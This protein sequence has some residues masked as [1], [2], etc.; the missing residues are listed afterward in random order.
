MDFLY[1]NSVFADFSRNVSTANHEGRLY[2]NGNL[3][4]Y[5]FE[6]IF[7]GKT[8]TSNMGTSRMG[9]S[10]NE[11]MG[12]SKMGTLKI[13]PQFLSCCWEPSEEL[14]NTSLTVM[15]VLEVFHSQILAHLPVKISSFYFFCSSIIKFHQVFFLVIL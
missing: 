8:V 14:D 9:T 1:A 13:I 6:Y 2:W 11:K 4:N 15:T 7:L 5:K 3:Q 12:T 10:K